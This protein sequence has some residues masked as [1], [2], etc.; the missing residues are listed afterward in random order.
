MLKKLLF[1]SPLL[2]VLLLCASC[3]KAE[4]ERSS[5]RAFMRF[6][7]VTGAPQL[8]AALTSPGMFC[9]VTFSAQYYIF[10]APDGKSTS[11]PRTALDA[12]GQPQFIAGFIVG[13][14]PG[15]DMNGQTRIVAYDLACPTCYNASALT[16]R[17]TLDLTLPYARCPQCN[18][19][20]DLSNKGIIIEGDRGNN[21]ETYS[22]AYTPAQDAVVIQN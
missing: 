15:V 16:K 22:I 6:S 19:L 8:L 4:S 7:P 14:P 13:M 9:T 10:T 20:Y 17:L 11:Y 3:D 5:Y 18:R 12:Y 21:L 2:A 1:L